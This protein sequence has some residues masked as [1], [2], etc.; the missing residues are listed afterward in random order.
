MENKVLGIQERFDLAVGCVGVPSKFIKTTN[1]RF[2]Y[3]EGAENNFGLQNMMAF[4]GSFHTSY[5]IQV[6]LDKNEFIITTRNSTYHFE[7]LDEEFLS[8]FEEGVL[9][10]L[11]EKEVEFMEKYLRE[12]IGL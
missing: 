11:S 3:Y 9:F 10:E 7:I 5:I 1:Q 4:F 2:K 8:W 12:G 6:Y